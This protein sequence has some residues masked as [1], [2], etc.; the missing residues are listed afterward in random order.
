MN[1]KSYYRTSV[2]LTLTSVIG[3]LVEGTEDEHQRIH[4]PHVSELVL[5]VGDLILFDTKDPTF[6]V[7]Y[8][9]QSGKVTNR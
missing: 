6:R 4:I 7:T 9:K 8:K 3:S 1:S 2:L 5:A